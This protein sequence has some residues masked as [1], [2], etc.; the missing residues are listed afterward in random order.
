[1]H[2]DW[3]RDMKSSFL[4]TGVYFP[5]SPLSGAAKAVWRFFP[6]G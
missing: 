4:I 3:N 1:M 6:S 2:L 5:A